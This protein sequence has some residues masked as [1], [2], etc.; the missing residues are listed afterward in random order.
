LLLAVVGDRD[1]IARDIDAK[2]IFN[3][4][5]RIP[6]ADKDFIIVV[7]DDHGKPARAST[8]CIVPSPASSPPK[9]RF[10]ALHKI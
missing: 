8:T 6:L 4:T 5:T 2:R 10:G 7:S 9:R 1:M 3:E